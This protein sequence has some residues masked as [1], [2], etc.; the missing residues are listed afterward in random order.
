MKRKFLAVLALVIISFCAL[1]QDTEISDYGKFKSYFEKLTNDSDW[2]RIS[3]PLELASNLIDNERIINEVVQSVHPYAIF[4]RGKC[5]VFI[6]EIGYP[7][8]GYTAAFGL[9]S[10]LDESMKQ[11]EI[12]GQTTLTNEGGRQSTINFIN[13]TLLEVM[14]EEV[15][16]DVITVEEKVSNTRYNYYIIN[17]DGFC[18]VAKGRISGARLFPQT[19]NRILDISELK[20]YQ[21]ADLDIMRNEIFADHGYIFKTEKWKRYFDKQHWYSPLY[22]DVTDELTI[23]EKV[24]IDNIL[25]VNKEKR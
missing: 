7:M 21:K 15:E 23:I 12:I 22:N 6:I 2:T 14:S 11:A 4:V 25:T 1:P 18:K 16:Y 9:L 20:N 24:N 10:F 5:T 8:G 3:I 19:S 17:T 13:D